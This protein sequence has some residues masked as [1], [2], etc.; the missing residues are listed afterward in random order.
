MDDLNG[1]VDGNVG[2]DGDV[3]EGDDSDGVVDG[4]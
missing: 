1:V 3:A 4:D 2:V